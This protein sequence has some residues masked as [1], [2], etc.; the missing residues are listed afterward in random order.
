VFKTWRGGEIDYSL[1]SPDAEPNH[2]LL[3]GPFTNQGLASIAGLDGLFALSFFWHISAL[4]ADGLKPLADL[5]KLGF[6]GCEGKLCNDEAMSHIG[7]MPRLRM[8]MAQGTVAN[9]AGFAALSRSHTIEYIWGRE[10]PNLRG[11][12]FAALAA[13]PSLKGLAV[14][15]KK[16]DDPSLA[17]LPRFPALRGLMPMDVSDDGFR[18]VGR[19]E[20]LEHLWCMYCRKTG[21]TATSHIAG[22]SRLKTYYA[23][24]TKITD[25]SLEMLGKVSSLESIEFHE[26]SRITNAG[27]A[28]LAGLPHLREITVGG[29]PKVTH[30][31]MAVFPATVR[32]NYW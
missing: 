10:C 27:V 6:L 4:T 26:C 31:G 25:R 17:A 3:D 13:M 2:L 29:S 7:A 8:L 21:D 11:R 30:E 14:S 24:A 5:P 19:C 28:L 16:V 20:Q 9:D 1:M 15:C 23:G 22:L 12:G 18:H 32:A